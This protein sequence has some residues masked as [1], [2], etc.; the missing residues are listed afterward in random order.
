[1]FFV[2]LH[3]LVKSLHVLFEPLYGYFSNE[4]F[5]FL[6]AL[7]L[8]ESR[9]IVHILVQKGFYFAFEGQFFDAGE[10]W[11]ERYIF[12][13]RHSGEKALGTFITKLSYSLIDLDIFVWC[14]HFEKSEDRKVPTVFD[15]FRFKRQYFLL[16]FQYRFSRLSPRNSRCPLHIHNLKMFSQIFATCSLFQVLLHNHTTILI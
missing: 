13:W 1:M 14:V 3:V 15:T 2:A 11:E 9:E 12:P 6:S 10:A 16:L 8:F 4:L 5:Y 7:L